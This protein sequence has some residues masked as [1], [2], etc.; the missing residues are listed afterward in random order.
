ERTSDEEAAATGHQMQV[1]DARR[2]RPPP[3]ARERA[4]EPLRAIPARTSTPAA[5]SMRGRG[6]LAGQLLRLVRLPVLHHQ[7]HRAVVLASVEG[8]PLQHRKVGPLARLERP[9]VAIEAERRGGSD[10]REDRQLWLHALFS[11]C[12][13]PGTWFRGVG[14]TSLLLCSFTA[15]WVCAPQKFDEA[16]WVAQ[17]VA[18]G[19]GQVSSIWSGRADLNRRPPAPKAVKIAFNKDLTRRGFVPRFS[20]N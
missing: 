7:Y 2:V 5:V 3:R 16:M 9:E 6:A 18:R 17:R 8:V 12:R 13:L 10:E 20:C 4:D 15:W 19:E 14:S 11:F 1:R